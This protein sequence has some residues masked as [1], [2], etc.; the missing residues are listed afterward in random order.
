MGAEQYSFRR[1]G[2]NRSTLV[3]V[4]LVWSALIAAVVL[5]DAALWLMAV[6]ALAT[7]PAL[8]DL[9]RNP[10]AGL[11]LTPQEL[12]WFSGRRKALLERGE[13]ERVRFDTRLDFSVRATAV[14][15]TGRRIRLPFECTPPIASFESALAAHGIRTERN[16]F[17]PLG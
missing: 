8:W 10:S 7:L 12:S 2:R 13:I 1:S 16:H 5:V 14:L 17:S 15:T 3:G 4:I 6:L 11:D 9:M